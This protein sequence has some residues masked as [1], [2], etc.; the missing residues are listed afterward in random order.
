MFAREDHD[1]VPR[2]DTYWNETIARW[3]SE[4]L[5]GDGGTVLELLGNDLHNVTGVWPVPFPGRNET[6]SED[7]E[8]RV[9]VDDWGATVR[10]WK[11]RSGTPEHIGFGCST[12]EAWEKEYKPAFLDYTWGD[13]SPWVPK[14]FAEGREANKWCYLTA[15]E[16]FE[17]TRRLMGD[18][19]TWIAMMENPDWV[20]DVSRT[21]TD[22][23][24]Q[25]LDAIMASGIEPDGLWTFGDMAYNHAPVC[26]PQT[27]R[28]LLW[29]DH[30]RLA[31]WAHAH[32]MKFIFHTDGNVNP[33]VDLFLE[34]GFD[35]LQPLESK[36][37]M[38]VRE[39]CPEY[40]DRLACF[41]NIDAM[42]M[43]QNDPE[44]LEEEVRTKL[45]AGKAAKNYIYHSDH[46]VPPTVSWETYRYLM[47][48]L[49]K[50]GRY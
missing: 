8:T 15:L 20:A 6:V 11:S 23:I 48:L 2:C 18:E 14:L 50:Y 29:P 44:V 33:V 5:D 38:D 35:C 46:S 1:R 3:Q 16:S 31:D 40:G 22:T 32:G 41:G 12:P 24:I 27:Y 9:W 10:Y 21:Y 17:A 25:G 47:E 13:F 37:S 45:E 36:A 34:A 19:V 4:G 26:S 30:K 28:D 7:E 42:V 43:G 39:L 49:D